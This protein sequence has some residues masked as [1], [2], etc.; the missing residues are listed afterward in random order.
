MFRLMHTA[1]ASRDFA[2]I[3]AIAVSWITLLAWCSPIAAEAVY[4]G[5]AEY[6]QG[7]QPYIYSAPSSATPDPD[8]GVTLLPG[9]VAGTGN[10]GAAGDY[11]YS[12][13]IEMPPAIG[14]IQPSLRAEYSSRG[15]YGD[16]GLG[17]RLSGLAT[18]S[19]CGRTRA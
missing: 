12:L 3:K 4:Y 11:K 14:S 13:P 17:W 5:S 10:V 18:I 15:G 7:V 2:Y 1:H 19:R 6:N 9:S 8:A 16:I